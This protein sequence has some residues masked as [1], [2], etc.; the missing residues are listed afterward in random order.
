MAGG[1]FALSDIRFVR[2][3]KMTAAYR[4]VKAPRFWR[5]SGAERRQAGG[6]AEEQQADQAVAQ[7]G[8]P[9]L[10]LKKCASMLP[11]KI[12]VLI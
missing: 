10:W 11:A 1:K 9:F 12:S 7:F 8:Q 2:R 4:G 5:G 3:D 6:K